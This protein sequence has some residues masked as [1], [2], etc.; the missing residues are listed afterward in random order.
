MSHSG[1]N[2][3]FAKTNPLDSRFSILFLSDKITIQQ[4]LLGRTSGVLFSTNVQINA[5]V[6]HPEIMK[7]RDLKRLYY[8]AEISIVA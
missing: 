4:P 1:F 5:Q 8:G 3:S 7:I 6:L 2:L